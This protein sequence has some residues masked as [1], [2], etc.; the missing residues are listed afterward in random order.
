MRLARLLRRR[1]PEIKPS[2]FYMDIQSFDRDFEKRL[3]TARKEVRLIR[4]I[5]SEFVW[6]LTVVRNWFTA[7]RTKT[8]SFESFDLV[9][10][11][12]GI[13]PDPSSGPLATTPGVQPNADAF[14]G[15]EGDGVLLI[16]PE[17]S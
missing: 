13:A 8:R 16:Q 4:A 9:V 14:L 3:A 7:G 17:F 10:L 5:P 2:M 15:P 1:F 11:S 12:V 6:A